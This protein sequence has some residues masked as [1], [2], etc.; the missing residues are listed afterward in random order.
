MR[1]RGERKNLRRIVLFVCL[2]M[3]LSLAVSAHPGR[4]DANGGHYNH[5]TGEYHYH[6]TPDSSHS[7]SGGTYVDDGEYEDWGEP[8]YSSANDSDDSGTDG[9]TIVLIIL[10]IPFALFLVYMCLLAV[11]EKVGERKK[12]ANKSTVWQN[13]TEKET[14]KAATRNIAPRK[15]PIDCDILKEQEDIEQRSPIQEKD[16][17]TSLSTMT[18]YAPVIRRGSEE[19]DLPIPLAT[20]NSFEIEKIKN[21]PGVNLSFFTEKGAREMLAAMETTRLERALKERIVFENIEVDH[22]TSPHK[23]KTVANSA[24]SNAKYR[25]SLVSCTCPDFQGRRLPCK[26]MIAL[27][28]RVGAVDPNACNTRPKSDKAKR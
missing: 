16:V 27:A 19:I 8:G 17:A 7:S 4:T 3:C 26:H 23:V 6:G 25:T 15:P 24:K 11:I 1:G 5:A 20:P 22:A 18:G 14:E 10:S 12:R 21:V 2:L 9:G 13:R 28:I